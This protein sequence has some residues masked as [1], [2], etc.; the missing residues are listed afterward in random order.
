[1]NAYIGP[2]MQ[3]YLDRLVNRVA[4]IGIPVKPYTIHSNGGLMSIPT[5]R[6]YPVRTCLSGPAAGV[7]GAAALA[8]GSGIP[9]VI[10][11]DVGGTS[12][13]VS[14]IANGRPQFTTNREVASHPVKTPMID[15]HVIGAGGGSIASVDSAGTLRVGPE[16]A[17][18]YPGPVA[19]MRGGTVPTLTDANVVLGR[20]NPSALLE[21]KMPVDR[22]GAEKAIA[23][24]VAGPLGIDVE[25]AAYGVLRIA[26]SNMARAIRAVSVERGFNLSDF[27]LFAYGGA[28]PL[29]AVEVAMECGMDMVLVP[30]EPG[31]LC[32]RGMLMSDISFDFVR[33][34]I[35]PLNPENW[36][37]VETI[38]REMRSE[39]D[40]WLAGENVAPENRGFLLMM[41]TRYDGQ[42]HEVQ[43]ELPAAS[44]GLKDFVERF[45]AAHRIE[46]GYALPDRGIEMVNYRVRAVGEVP[47][48]TRTT[49]YRKG[50]LEQAVS[51]ERRT[52]L[53]P[54]RGWATVKVYTR[55]LLPVGAP[56]VG[57]AIIEEMSSTTVVFPDQAASV[58]AAGNVIIRLSA[59]RE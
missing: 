37:Q 15:I 44:A 35:R 23:M 10:T 55:S 24:S 40:E 9:N 59:G 26:T 8:R 20:L 58:D 41:D 31:T 28:G 57:P 30:A 56:V 6:R 43:V 39:A 36:Q 29:H 2:M 1:M 22:E 25:R 49:S 34:G 3:G 51:A 4:A 7:M 53:D 42:N 18:A 17:G 54:D 48:A 52:F 16:S 14:L 47:K 12:T 33:S 5:V 50:H 45:E 38:F 27:T 21:G 19:Y 13:D 46:Y 11:F 32:A